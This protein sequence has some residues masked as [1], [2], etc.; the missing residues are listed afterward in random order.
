MGSR[1]CSGGSFRLGIGHPEERQR[2]HHNLRTIG[3]ASSRIVPCYQL[4]LAMVKLTSALQLPKQ[5]HPSWRPCIK[6]NM[7]MFMQDVAK[8]ISD[9]LVGIVLGKVEMR[10]TYAHKCPDCEPLDAIVAIAPT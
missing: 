5:T 8:A 7:V 1:R 9:D 3:L 4:V 10:R 6:V 2:V